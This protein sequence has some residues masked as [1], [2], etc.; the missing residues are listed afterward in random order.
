MAKSILYLSDQATNSSSVAT[1]LKATGHEVVSTDCSTKA[2]SLLFLVKSVAAV[3]FHAQE[4][5]QKCFAWACSMRTLRP[6]ITIILLSCKQID[7]LPP[8]VDASVCTGEPEDNLVS[9]VRYLLNEK[10]RLTHQHEGHLP[11][12]A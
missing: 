12:A 3:V 1:A 10:P 6:E 5:M 4:R 2:I 8:C 9:A 11:R 7:P